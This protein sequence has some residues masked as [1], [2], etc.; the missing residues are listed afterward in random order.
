M[1]NYSKTNQCVSQ[2]L[3]LHQGTKP[4]T[5]LTFVASTGKETT[6]SIHFFNGKDET[7]VAAHDHDW[8]VL[9]CVRENNTV[10]HLT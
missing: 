6:S 8:K 10:R 3:L 9:A 4:K 5:R 1:Y 2:S 7:S